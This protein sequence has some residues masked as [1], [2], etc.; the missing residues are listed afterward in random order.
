MG[1][2]TVRVGVIGAG[3]WG[4]MHVRAYAQH[5]SAELVGVC[6]LDEARAQKLA[7]D[8]GVPKACTSVEDLLAEGL[9]AVSIATP[10]TAH[11]EPAVLAASKGV[12]VLVEKPLAT[13]VEECTR[14]IDAAK[15][16]DVLLMVDWHNRWNPPVHEAWRTIRSGELGKIT[17]VYYR[18]N[19]TIFVPTKMLPWA[20]KSSVLLFLGSHAFDTVCW[21]LDEAPVRVS[22]R[23]K[24]DILASMGIPTADMYLT[25]FEFAGGATAIVENSWVIPQSAPTLIDHRWEII[26]SDGVLY[27]DAT[28]NRAVAKYTAKTPAGFPDASYPDMF[29]TP[30]IHNRQMGFCVEPMYQFVECIRDGKTPLTSGAD[31]LL[32]TRILLAAE[33]SARL[34][35]PVALADF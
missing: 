33:E 27:F 14:M 7:S 6:D 15:E 11:C 32:N 3:I 22:C 35:K 10:D 30:E 19:D 26:G 29:V 25:T 1:G 8:H 17:Y 23:R 13:S 20:G 5:A 24:D 2:K 9:D 28:H 12:H 4:S 31:G 21:L 34:G 18:L 16:N